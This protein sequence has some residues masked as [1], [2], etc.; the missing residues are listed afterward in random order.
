MDATFD[1][2]AVIPANADNVKLRLTVV[3]VGAAAPSEHLFFTDVLFSGS[4]AVD[5][6]GDGMSDAYETANGLNPNSAADKFLDLDNDGQ[7]NYQ[8]FLAGTAANNPASKLDFTVTNLNATT[9]AFTITWTSVP[10]KNY[11]VQASTSL[12]A[13][14]W[15]DLTPNLPASAGT[16]TTL[17]GTLP[18]PLASHSFFSVRVVP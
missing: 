6:D 16:T 12:A 3:G 1:L 15:T 8:E 17:S 5:T 9:G 11:R 4:G 14:S 7:N 2:S 10:G 18:G 13:G